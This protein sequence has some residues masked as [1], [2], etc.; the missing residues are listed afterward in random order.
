MTIK[1]SDLSKFNE[2]LVD[3]KILIKFKNNIG[4]MKITTKKDTFIYKGTDY[5][6]IFRIYANITSTIVDLEVNVNKIVKRLKKAQ[7]F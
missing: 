1:L 7:E 4:Y 5:S 3:P 6:G 2:P